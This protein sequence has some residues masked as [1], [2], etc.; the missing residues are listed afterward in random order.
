ME[1]VWILGDQLRRDVGALRDRAPGEVRVL[2]VES[3]GLFASKRWHRQRAHLVLAAMRRFALELRAEGFEVDLREAAT[4]RA[5]LLAHRA[6]FSPTRVV[7]MSPTSHDALR[8]L[9]RNEVTIIDNE[10]FICSTAAFAAWA[11]GRRMMRMEDFY[12]WQRTRTGVLMDDGEPVGGRWNFDADNREPPP[13]D[14]RSW[15]APIH[16]RLDALDARVMV[17]V[18]RRC[19]E[20][21]GDPP[22]GLWPTT[23]T[24]ALA[25]LTRFVDEVLPL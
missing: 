20:L 14:G 21:F 8:M 1:T 12:R 2:M 25:R 23:R 24:A 10:Q 19:P 18:E 9:E 15:P 5:G 16:D 3:L 4:L 11:A 13:T 7:A 22:D 17:D 6:E